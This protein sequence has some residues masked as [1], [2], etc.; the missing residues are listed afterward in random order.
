MKNK[1]IV[2]I[3]LAVVLACAGGYK[4]FHHSAAANINAIMVKA[5]P[6][7]E[8]NLPQEIHVI[9]TLAA[10]SVQ[11]TPEIA[12]HV[13]TV[14]FKDGTTVTRGM[15]LLQLDDAVYKARYESAK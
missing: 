4:L 11:I 2:G 5:S 3:V 15:V 8:A 9:G 1:I 7:E 10:R 14:L 6:V 12:G 13:N